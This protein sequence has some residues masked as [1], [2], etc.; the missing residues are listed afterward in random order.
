MYSIA[1]NNDFDKEVI[2]SNEPLVVVDFHNQFCAPCKM[3]DPVLQEL[4][5]EKSIKVVKVNSI[6]FPKIAGQYNIRAV[7]ALLF[8]KEGNVVEQRVGFTA[9][10]QLNNI[11]DQL[12]A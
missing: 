6:D 12:S 5:L 9:I 1:S 2:L 7:P 10:G 11:V 4:S 3:Q 8:F